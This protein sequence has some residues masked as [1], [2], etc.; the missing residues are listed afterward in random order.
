MQKLA[1]TTITLPEE[2][3]HTAKL[4]ALHQKKSLSRIINEALED[5]ITP[6]RRVLLRDPMELLGIYNLGIGKV[7][8]SRSDLYEEHVR[9]KM[10]S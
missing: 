1:R 2:T 10:G 8:K 6:K 9:R 7:Y 5:K 3:M 4:I